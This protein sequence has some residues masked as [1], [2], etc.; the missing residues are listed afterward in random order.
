MSITIQ[1]RSVPAGVH[2]WLKAQR[3]MEGICTSTYVRRL[4]ERALE[5]PNCRDALDRLRTL[6]MIE[7]DLSAAEIL[8]KAREARIP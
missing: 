3:A 4:L 8:R 2:R 6:P 5:R 7:P 1:I